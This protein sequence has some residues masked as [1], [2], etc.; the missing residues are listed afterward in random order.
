MSVKLSEIVFVFAKIGATAFGG[1]AAHI[2][3][4]EEEVVRRRSWIT[5]EEFLDLISAT[6]LIPGP[7]STELAIHVGYRMRGWKGLLASGIAFICP[8]FFIVLAIAWFYVSYGSLPAIQSIFAAVKPVIV[9]IIAQAVW[10][11]SKTAIKDRLLAVL[12]VFS[13]GVYLVWSHEI[14]ILVAVGFLN[15]VIRGKISSNKKT[16]FALIF[17]TFFNPLLRVFAQVTDLYRN[18]TE[19]V[20]WYFVKVGSVLFGSGYVLIAFL[21]ND[22]VNQYQWITQQ[23]LVD[24]IAVGQFTPGPVFTTA[25]FIGYLISGNLGAIASTIGIFLP[26]FVFVALSAPFI[27]KLRKSDAVAFF[28]DGLN[29]ASLSLMLGASLLLAQNTMNSIYGIVIFAMSLVL[30]LKFKINSAWLVLGASVLGF[31]GWHL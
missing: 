29:V 11:L 13:L 28:L 7:N 10:S 15:L 9:A 4:M 30:L 20:F 12:A 31:L 23:Q 21:Q 24:A 16:F 19:H 2:A 17:F 18:S 25:T 22:L 26:A 8:A 6:N 3:M 27:P 5:Q 1:P 14:L